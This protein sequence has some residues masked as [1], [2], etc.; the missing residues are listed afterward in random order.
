MLLGLLGALPVWAAD[1]LGALAR[2]AFYDQA[3]AETERSSRL[4]LDAAEKQFGPD[5]PEAGL[6]M[7]WLADAMCRA[8]STLLSRPW[9]DRAHT[10]A[11]PIAQRSIEILERAYG[12]DDVRTAE[13][14]MAY[15]VA[16]AGLYRHPEGDPYGRAVLTI[17]ERTPPG[18]DQDL[19]ILK[20]Y[21][22]AAH[23]HVVDHNV[24]AQEYEE[25]TTRAQYGYLLDPPRGDD[26]NRVYRGGE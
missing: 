21:Y 7:A 10:Q 22:Y 9:T 13:V 23:L 24:E 17:V 4:G 26:P 20:L 16:L 12:P 11:L 19:L 25:R 3:W 14:H 15:V 1:D 8:D 2:A 6:W 5:S 18:Q